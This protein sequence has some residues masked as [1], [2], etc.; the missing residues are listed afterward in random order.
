MDQPAKKET[1]QIYIN[2]TRFFL[3]KPIYFFSCIETLLRN[4]RNQ[5]SLTEKIYGRDIG[6]DSI[7]DHVMRPALS[8][9]RLVRGA[10]NL[11]PL[12][13]APER[14]RVTLDSCLVAR[15]S[16]LL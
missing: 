11:V 3:N 9:Q 5:K 10:G 6:Q 14:K 7:S 2:L 15:P 4:I 1:S 13:A 8:D 16:Q 12:A